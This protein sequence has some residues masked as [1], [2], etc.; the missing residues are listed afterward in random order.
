[1]APDVG[2]E[3]SSSDGQSRGSDTSSIRLRIPS[4]DLQDRLAKA[5]GDKMKRTAD[6]EEIQSK[7]H[8]AKSRKSGVAE[9]DEEDVR[10]WMREVSGSANDEASSSLPLFARCKSFDSSLLLLIDIAA[11][12]RFFLFERVTE[13]DGKLSKA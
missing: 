13:D 2:E 5:L 11:A 12:R 6:A 10:M 9:G 1:M 7:L 8:R 3:V 4:D